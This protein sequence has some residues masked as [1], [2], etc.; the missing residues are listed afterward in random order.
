MTRNHIT[1]SFNC[2]VEKIRNKPEKFTERLGV[3][4]V[5]LLPGTE[6]KD[7]DLKIV[8]SKYWD[9]IPKTSLQ[10]APDMV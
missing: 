5:I 3:L 1:F 2:A 8:F 7:L 9:C 4:A 6:D 10:G